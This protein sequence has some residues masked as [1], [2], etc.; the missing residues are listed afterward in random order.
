MSL[1]H[2]RRLVSGII[3]DSVVAEY[4]RRL[5][6]TQAFRLKAGIYGVFGEGEYI[7]SHQNLQS[8][9]LQPIYLGSYRA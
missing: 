7:I 4:A 1:W 9:S 6:T 3:G 2:F 5:V 8:N